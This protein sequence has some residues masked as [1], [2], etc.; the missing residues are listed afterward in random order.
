MNG[1]ARD[2]LRAA[3]DANAKARDRRTRP[4]WKRSVREAFLETLRRE[5]YTRLLE[6][7][8]GAGQDGAFFARQGLDVICVDLSPKMVLLCREKGLEAY[9]MDVTDLRFPA[10]SFD[11][12]TSLN[13]LLHLPKAEL[14]EALREVQR[15]LR[16]GGVFYLGVYG[17]HDEEGIWEQD[18]Y[19][20]KRFFS[21]HT[22]EQLLAAVGA[23][24]D[25]ASFDRIAVEEEDAR[26]HV[27]SLILRKKTG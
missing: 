25:V 5:G 14:P 1:N 23:I 6:I 27:Q 10:E 3:Y 26:F 17:G 15:V 13:S 2:R 11:A 7:G 16:P 24:F 21:F 12:A 19:D 18:T 8:S 9:V 20:P 4:A 22:D